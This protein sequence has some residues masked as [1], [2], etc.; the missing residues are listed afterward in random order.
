MPHSHPHDEF[1]ALDFAARYINR[2]LPLE[3]MIGATDGKVFRFYH[4]CKTLDLGIRPGQEAAADDVQPD[5][6]RNDRPVAAEL[7]AEMYGVPIKTVVAPIHDAHGRVIGTLETGFDLSTQ[8]ELIAIADQFTQ[9]A[10]AITERLSDL[11]SRA[12]RLEAIQDHLNAVC[13]DAEAQLQRS[14][15]ILTLIR[16]ITKQT[17]MLGI[18]AR[19]EAARSGTAAQSFA[20]VANEIRQLAER[21]ATS[22][23]EVEEALKRIQSLVR[24]IHDQVSQAADSGKTQTTAIAAISDRLASA[25]ETSREVAEVAQVI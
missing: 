21:V 9:S 24:R 10:H 8:Q 23:R 5:V 1:A 11:S 7:G 3:T 16:D 25:E 2:L 19:I 15:K 4:P 6:I 18:N 12:Q 14:E 22:A 17:G 20:V 13:S